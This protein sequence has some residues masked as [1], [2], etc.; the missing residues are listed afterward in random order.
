MKFGEETAAALAV[1]RKQ[2]KMARDY[3]L[4][5]AVSAGYQLTIAAEGLPAG[6][7][8]IIVALIRKEIPLDY[9]QIAVWWYSVLMGVKKDPSVFLEFITYIRANRN[10][11]SL[12]TQYFL[13]Y[14]LKSARFQFSV[15]HDPD[16]QR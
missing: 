3:L 7:Q 1:M 11:F 16:N 6:Q 10:A 14:Q 8:D 12:N 15:L 9:P 2:K 5:D 13:F 4:E